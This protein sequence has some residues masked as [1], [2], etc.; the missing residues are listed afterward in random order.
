MEKNQII[1]TIKETFKDEK[2]PGDDN[3]VYDNTGT[4]LECEQV[5]KTFAGHSWEKLHEIFLFEN[6]NAISF[7]SKE[8]FKYYVPAYMIFS[9]KKFHEADDAPD[10]LIGKF[11]LP[12]EID[13]VILANAI[14]QYRID[15][16]L[17]NIDFEEILQNQAKQNNNTLHR[18]FEYMHIFNN[19]QKSTIKNFLEYMIRYSNSLYYKPEVAIDRYWFQF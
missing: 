6:R 17:T 16:R 7:F 18:F 12:L 14:K 13:T 3:I 8:G 9:V 5:K 4:H 19:N 11:T 10:M 15:K 1:D 2:Y